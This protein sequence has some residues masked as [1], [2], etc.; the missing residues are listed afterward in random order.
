MKQH[1]SWRRMLLWLSG[2]LLAAQSLVIG[3]LAAASAIRKRRAPPASFP[4]ERRLIAEVESNE[5]RVYT[6]GQDLYNAMLAAIDD[7]RETIFLETFIW[8][9]DPLGQMFKQR[10]ERKAAAGVQVFVIYDG[11]ANLVVPLKFKR[12]SPTINVLEYRTLDRVWYI[13]DPRRYARDHRKLLVVDHEIA[14]L[15]G[16]NI[17]KLYATEW[18]DTHLRIRG[19]AARD[20]AHT[21]ADFW[22]NNREQRPAIPP[23]LDRPWP[24]QIKI[25]RNDLARLILPI[26]G[27]YL[28]AIE[29][30][31]HH[32][33][34]TNAYFIPDRVI[35]SALIQAAQR[36][37][38][39]RVL[40]PWQSNHP[41]ADWLARG[42]FGAFLRSGVRIFG[43]QN[44]MIHAKTATIDGQWSTI[45]TANL[46]RLSLA[47]NYEIN[48]EIYD[49]K[50]A[51]VMEHIFEI[52]LT[53]AFEMTLERWNHR[54]WYMWASE[55]LL[56][57]LRPLL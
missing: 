36:G 2:L 45:G 17:G 35:L 41:T 13:F 47:G 29:R 18:R 52:D 4:H 37:V 3:V 15:G 57:P 34:L 42:Y 46:D 28:E 40:L 27:M 24:G 48:V 10:L 53:N 14:F 25:Q 1:A 26:R 21:F 7:A 49:Q 5:V 32:I 6:Y 23:I 55:K 44:A 16:F 30:A 56:S 50:F 19:P 39:V 51:A 33:Y 22:N 54:P 20:I 9:G 43:F 31:Q 11:F 12:F 38:D 8:K